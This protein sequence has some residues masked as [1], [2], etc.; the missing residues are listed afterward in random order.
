ME[1]KFKAEVKQVLDIVIN[2]LYTDKEIFVRELVSNA[3]DA[4]SKL[5]MQKLSQACK[6]SDDE[7]KIEI[8]TDEK[9]GTFTIEDRGVGMTSAELISN[10]GTIAHSG[11][12]AFIEALKES[13]GELGEGLIGQFGVG[14]YSVFMVA[15]KVDVFTKSEADEAAHWSCDGSENFTIESCD[16]PERGTKIVATLKDE[17]KEFSQKSRIRAIAERYSAYIDFPILIDGQKLETRQAIWL[18]SKSDLKP[19]QYEEFYKFQTHAFDKPLDWLHFKSDV[20]LELNALIYTPSENT[21]RLGFG[22]T[23]CEVALYCKKVLIDSAPKKLFPEWMRFAKGVI[24]SS[25][26]PLNISRESMQDSGLSMKIGR[27]VLKRFLKH[28]A[29]MS[30]KDEKKFSEFT[31]R[32]GT[33]IKEGA[34]VDFEYRKELTELLRFESSLYADG[35]FVSLADYVGR[36]KPNQK[37]IFYACAQ[38]RAAIEASPYL[39][40]FAKRGIEVLFMYEP[41]D[42]FLVGNLANY[43]DKTFTSIDAADIELDDIPEESKDSSPISSEDI[44][45]LKSWI[46]ETLGNE[47]VSDVISDGKRLIEN[48]AAALNADSLTPQMRAM[49]KAMNPDSK[50]PPATVKFE[51]NPKSEVIKNLN[52]LR[53]NAPDLAKLVLEQLFDNALLSAGLLENPRS[54][55]KRMNEILSKVKP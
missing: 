15:K 25:D 2:S 41:I 19:E 4:S 10:L 54:M 38:D 17:Y 51:I 7:L 34:A 33:F 27:V 47:K 30:K 9:A 3:S 37:R 39:E 36:M 40:A 45:A 12:K 18:K 8:S 35:A 49:L 22:K 55:A 5:R 28:L 32:F 43:Q 52:S 11:S 20:P 48:P 42:A 14:F 23:E 13:K 6:I 53:K 1:Y 29:E 31:K 46:K 24:D 26:I 50:L 44:D 21:E 16:K